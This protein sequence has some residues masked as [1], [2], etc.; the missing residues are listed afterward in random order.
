VNVEVRTEIVIVRT[1]VTEEAVNISVHLRSDA[2]NFHAI[3]GREQTTSSRPAA[4][5]ETAAGAMQ[6]RRRHGERS[7]NSTG[8]VL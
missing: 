3:A 7:R 4:N 8:A 2:I 1:E 5:F 6:R